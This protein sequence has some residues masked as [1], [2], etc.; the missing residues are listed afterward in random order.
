MIK[1]KKIKKN[2]YNKKSWKTKKKD[3]EFFIKDFG[4]CF[5]KIVPSNFFITCT[6]VFGK[7]KFIK[8]LGSLKQI[9]TRKEGASNNAA[10]LLGAAAGNHAKLKGFVK[11]DVILTVR[12]QSKRVQSALFGLTSSGM[13]IRYLISK[14]LVS[15]NGVK[16]RKQKRR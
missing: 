6:D 14:N 7:V 10:Y 4:L 11:L 13:I 15:F 9:K 12:V 3:H 5:F 8:N 2:I 1:N 16:L